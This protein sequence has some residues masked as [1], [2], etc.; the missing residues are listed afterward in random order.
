MSDLGGSGTALNIDNI[1]PTSR[2]ERVVDTTLEGTGNVS[3]TRNSA[4][5]GAVHSSEP[6]EN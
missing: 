3:A 6:R 4:A 2:G 5:E 1:T